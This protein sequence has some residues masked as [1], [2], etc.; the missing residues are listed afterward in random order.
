MSDRLKRFFVADLNTRGEL[1]R[2]AYYGY[3]QL[4]QIPGASE[5]IVPMAT[6]VWRDPEAFDLSLG[7]AEM[8]LSFR[9]RASAAT[10]G[11]G[12]L[13]SAG[14]LTSVCLIASGLDAEADAITLR[15]F[16]DRLLTGLRDTGYEPAFALVE[17]RERPLVA[18]IEFQ[19]PGQ[20]DAQY[21]AA[22]SDRC[23]AAAYFRR[24]SLV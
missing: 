1:Q 22:L 13:R 21:L 11:I 7:P 17:L 24:L 4:E 9:W 18:T 19:S 3:D 6:A 8:A 5:L 2:S 16:Q 10:A 14:E 15:A 20:H 12:T 23:F